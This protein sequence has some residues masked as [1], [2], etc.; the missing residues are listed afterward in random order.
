MHGASQAVLEVRDLPA[1]AGDVGDAGSIP[2][3]GRSPGGHGN[4]SS[5]L[6]WGITWTGEP[7]G[8]Q[9]KGSQRVRHD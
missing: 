9:S 2:G 6:A 7:G 1:S 3:W 4:R 8:L 5:V